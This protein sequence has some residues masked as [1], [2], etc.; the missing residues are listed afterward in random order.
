MWSVTASTWMET[1]TTTNTIYTVYNWTD[2]KI[3]VTETL[4]R[5]ERVIKKDTDGT[6]A[7]LWGRFVVLVI[8]D[9]TSPPNSVTDLKQHLFLHHTLRHN[10]ISTKLTFSKSTW[11]PIMTKR[12]RI[13][14]T[15]QWRGLYRSQIHHIQWFWVTV[16]THNH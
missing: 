13:L 12:T 15:A 14:H 16:I 1:V 6:V 2:T 4:T 9:Q 8:C 5:T 11:T 10:P 3:K 7:F